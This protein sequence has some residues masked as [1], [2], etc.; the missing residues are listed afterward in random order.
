MQIKCTSCGAPQEYKLEEKCHFCGSFISNEQ[1]VE[2]SNLSNFNLAIY[3]YEKLNLEKALSLFEQMLLNNPEN[4]VAWVYKINCEIRLK[5]PKE[6]HFEDFEKSVNWLLNNFSNI[7][8]ADLIENAI[9]E[10]IKYLLQLQV[11]RSEW[12]KKRIEGFLETID[13]DGEYSFFRVVGRLTEVFSKRFS[14]EF[15]DYLKS[16]VNNYKDYNRTPPERKVSNVVIYP[17]YLLDLHTVFL[18]SEIN[19]TEY[20]ISLM[21]TIKENDTLDV[22][23]GIDSEVEEWIIKGRCENYENWLDLNSYPSNQNDIEQ[24]QK[25]NIDF[26]RITSYAKERIN[27]IK[28]TKRKVETKVK[29]EP[30]KGCFIATATMG[31]YDHPVVMDLRMFRDNWLLKRD[32]GVRFTNWYYTHGPKAAHIIEKSFFLKRLTFIFVVK[33][34]QIITKNLK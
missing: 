15:L 1:Q 31:D 4:A 28:S 22:T 12:D 11:R 32:W 8:I 29:I 2:D 16:Y 21:S 27:E 17:W 24:I 30:K 18:K 10:T 33:P 23:E 34:L 20:L 6:N 19:A 9:L 13:T 25:L 26:G 7:N 5:A 14:I 3:E